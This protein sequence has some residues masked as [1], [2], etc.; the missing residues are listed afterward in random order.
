MAFL[1]NEALDVMDAQIRDHVFSGT[2]LA[3]AEEF[4]GHE[5]S[6]L[7][8]PF[9]SLFLEYSLNTIRAS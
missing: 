9:V 4:T 1:E 3:R 6:S 8:D 2:L 5:T 7:L